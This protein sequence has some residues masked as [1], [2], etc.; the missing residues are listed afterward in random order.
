VATPYLTYNGRVLLGRTEKRA[1]LWAGQALMP[2][3]EVVREVRQGAGVDDLADE[4]YVTPTFVRAVLQL[5]SRVALLRR[6][7][8][9]RAPEASAM[10]AAA[11]REAQARDHDRYDERSKCMASGAQRGCGAKTGKRIRRSQ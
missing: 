6:G 9:V 11:E 7:G 4:F 10:T 1:L 5:P 8:G 2:E 3:P